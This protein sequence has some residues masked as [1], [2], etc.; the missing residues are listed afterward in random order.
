MW[1][2]TVSSLTRSVCDSVSG[3]K[4]SENLAPVKHFPWRRTFWNYARGIAFAA[5]SPLKYSRW[6][7]TASV[8]SPAGLA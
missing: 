4:C 3:R 8:A 2:P 1:I 5:S 7:A 6:P